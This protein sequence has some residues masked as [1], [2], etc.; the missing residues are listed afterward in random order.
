MNP[1]NAEAH[2]GF[3][4]WLLC[5]GR[6]DEAVAWI[7]RARAL[8]PLGVSGGNVSWILFQAHRYEEAIRE[9]RSALAIQPDNAGDLTGL[10][11]A[12]DR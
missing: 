6:T 2:S 10:G 11:F 1:N 9:S 4:L 5:Q 8:D 3:A 7:Q 12:S